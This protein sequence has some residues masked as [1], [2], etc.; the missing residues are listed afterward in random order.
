MSDPCE[1]HSRAGGLIE[2]R[3]LF[4]RPPTVQGK[5][6]LEISFGAGGFN[7]SSG[8][9]EWPVQGFPN[10]RPNVFPSTRVKA[11]KL[12][13]GKNGASAFPVSTLQLF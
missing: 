9:E 3:V 12:L 4:I 2:H 11:A 5:A 8:E 6:C 7:L 1:G 10:V 13:E